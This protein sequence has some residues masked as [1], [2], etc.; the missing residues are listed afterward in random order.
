MKKTIALL[1]AGLLAVIVLAKTTNVSSY[2]GTMWSKAKDAAKEQVP[3]EFDMDRINHEIA[4]LD[5]KVKDMIRPVA[6]HKVAVDAL[7]RQIAQD[8]VKLSDQKKVLLDATTAVKNAKKGEE[9]VYGGKKYTADQVKARIALDFESFKRFESTITAQ[10][11]LLESREKTLRAAEDQLQSFMA[12][13]EEFRLQLAQL[14]AEHEVNK[15]A[16]VGTSVEIDTTPLASI[17]Q[18][19]N[20]LRERIDRQRTELEYRNGILA[21]NG[22]KLDQPQQNAAVD[23]DAI[24]AHLEHGPAAKTTSTASNK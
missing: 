10:R 17:S 13:K 15:V 22:L 24:Q 12:K 3:T 21:L 6:Q 19:L 23:L 9:L 14:R 16:A 11:S 4:G 7:R 18:S 8:E 5:E 2:V 1:A 20:E